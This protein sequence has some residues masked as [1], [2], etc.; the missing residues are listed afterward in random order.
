MYD[1]IAQALGA[2][3]KHTEECRPSSSPLLYFY[4]CYQQFEIHFSYD[5]LKA[6]YYRT[7][8]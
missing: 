6:K 7:A 4:F 8:E 1:Y 3:S 5:K 2:C